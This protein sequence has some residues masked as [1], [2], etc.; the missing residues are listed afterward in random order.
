MSLLSCECIWCVMCRDTFWGL[1][2]DKVK[3]RGEWC[4]KPLQLGWSY[5]K[6]DQAWEQISACVI[7]L[8]HFRI[9][10]HPQNEV[11]SFKTST[12]KH[13][14]KSCKRA[15]YTMGMIKRPPPWAFYKSCFY[16]RRRFPNVKLALHTLHFSSFQ[17]FKL[18]TKHVLP[19]VL[20]PS[21][22]FLKSSSSLVLILLAWSVHPLLRRFFRFSPGHDLCS[23][24][25]A[26]FCQCILG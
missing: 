14:A 6:T 19:L 4:R 10:S 24:L 16:N 15:S 11:T 21:F 18:R 2:I 22:R 9:Y 3:G 1:G 13:F 17:L 5:F 20:L 8:K 7:N 26:L 23:I 12:F 25:L